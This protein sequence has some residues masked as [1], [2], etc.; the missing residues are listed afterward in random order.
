MGVVEARLELQAVGQELGFAVAGQ[1]DAQ[2]GRPHGQASVARRR[3]GYPLPRAGE[4]DLHWLAGVR[5]AIGSR[6]LRLRIDQL[7]WGKVQLQ[8]DFRVL[9]ALEIAGGQQ[10]DGRLMPGAV[11]EDFDL[12]GDRREA[13]T[14]AL[15]GDGQ[16]ALAEGGL[17]RQALQHRVGVFDEAGDVRFH[18][19]H[20]RGKIVALRQ[21]EVVAAA[22][23][24]RSEVP[25]FQADRDPAAVADEHHVRLLEV[26]EPEQV[27]LDRRELGPGGL[28]RR[29]RAIQP[30]ASRLLRVPAGRGCHGDR[31]GRHHQHERHA[32]ALGLHIV[33]L[34]N[35]P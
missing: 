11:T 33:P 18:V 34:A 30:R 24:A 35:R 32:Q 21:L 27:L 19:G 25:L 9:G 20:R 10:G 1:H 8:P 3:A 4:R 28:A 6:L 2:C 13:G 16:D 29:R 15:A 23:P 12:D 31:G 7:G 14:G 22:E 5:L 26:Q 17:G